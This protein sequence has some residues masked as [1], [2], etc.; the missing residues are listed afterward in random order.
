MSLLR[1]TPRPLW[2]A[3]L[4]AVGLLVFAACGGDEEEGPPAGG[5]TPAG[6]TPAGGLQPQPERPAGAQEVQE[7]AV[8]PINGV[9]EVS[10]QDNFF[11]K[12]HFEVGVGEA[13]TFSV[14]NDGGSAHT[15][16]LA[17]VDGEFGTEDDI[18]TEVLSG[19]EQEDLQA[20]LEIS[21][22]YVFRCNQHPTQMWGEVHVEEE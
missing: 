20:T 4:L 21:G 19:G 9:I 15:F 3:V 14:S 13:A 22:T 17:G 6:G 1:S 8:A 16:T 7:E 12:N 5:G 10:A 11:A 18:S 2:I